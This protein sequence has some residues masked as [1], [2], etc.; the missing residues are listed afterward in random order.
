M[1]LLQI[2]GA[3]LGVARLSAQRDPIAVALGITVQ[4]HRQ[5]RDWSEEALAYRTGLEANDIER[6]EA[7]EGSPSLALVLRLAAG[8]EVS[9]AELVRAVEELTK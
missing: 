3:L 6:I 1:P 4:W 7:G 9:A 5:E 2:A 8:L